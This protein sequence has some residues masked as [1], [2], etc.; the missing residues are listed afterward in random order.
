MGVEF[1]FLHVS[2]TFIHPLGI[3][4][5]IK[6]ATTERRL[7]LQTFW[8]PFSHSL[9]YFFKI[10]FLS[11]F[12]SHLSRHFIITYSVLYILQTPRIVV[13][14]HPQSDPPHTTHDNNVTQFHI[15]VKRVCCPFFSL[16]SFFFVAIIFFNPIMVLFHFMALLC[17]CCARQF[18][19]N[20]HE[21]NK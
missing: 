7:T 11:L 21:F 9:L 6:S 20:Y 14:A 13:Q 8:R 5:F 17:C 19:Y 3:F 2:V 15:R 18:Q 4:F 16:F 1:L 10:F 12:Q